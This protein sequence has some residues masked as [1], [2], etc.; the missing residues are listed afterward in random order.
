[1]FTPSVPA[2]GEIPR[3]LAPQSAPAGTT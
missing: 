2:A 3:S 1:M